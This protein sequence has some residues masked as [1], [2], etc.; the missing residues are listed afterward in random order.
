MC[1]ILDDEGQLYSA[2]DCLDITDQGANSIPLD[3]VNRRQVFIRREMPER[4][5]VIVFV[6]GVC[7]G[8]S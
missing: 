1:E 5:K 4:L 7:L 3:P 6:P 2:R 8:S